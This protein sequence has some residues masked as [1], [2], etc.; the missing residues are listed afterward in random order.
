[1]SRRP[2]AALATIT[3]PHGP[4]L[5]RSQHAR[6]QGGYVLVLDGDPLALELLEPRNRLCA[7]TSHRRTLTPPGG[8][9]PL[10]EIREVLAQYQARWQLVLQ[11]ARRGNTRTGHDP[12]RT[13]GELVDAHGRQH[14]AGLR[15]SSRAAYAKRWRSLYR[16]LPPITA[17][18]LIDRTRVQQ[19]VSDLSAAGLAPLTV[20][21]LA[22]AL[23]SVLDWSAEVGHLDR[24]PTAGL[25]LPPA[26]EVH[27]DTLDDR[28]VTRLLTAAE[29]Y[30]ADALL[31]VALAVLAGLRASE[32]LAVQWADV[33]MTAKTLRM[34]N[35]GA[36][37]TKNGR[38]RVIPLG[39]R[40]LAILA[41]HRQDAGFIV[42]PSAKA[43]SGRSRWSFR[44]TYSAVLAA[45]GIDH[46]PFHSLRRTFATRAV[47][48]GVPISKVRLWLGHSSLTVT[49]SYIHHGSGYDG[50]IDRATA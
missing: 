25:V 5:V 19:V 45:A 42:R 16:I 37:V 36:F 8:A 31:L 1:M 35:R 23:T 24:T 38:S 34:R 47:E 12:I 30:S 40:L 29:A 27:R 2:V 14:A 18:S 33:D 22:K 20:R 7:T 26:I 9:V 50:D 11:A 44:K 17:L 15:A 43:R 28:D 13:L 48:K 3:T 21:N 41:D 49:Q 6:K 39:E 46:L 4:V 10:T 32:V